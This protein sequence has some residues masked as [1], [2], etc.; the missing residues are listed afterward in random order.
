MIELAL[1]QAVVA[2]LR[3]DTDLRALISG[4][5]Y[6]ETPPQNKF[7][8]VFVGD[9]TVQESSEDYI[10]TDIEVT[11]QGFSNS[12]SLEEIFKITGLIRQILNT[13]LS[14]T[15]YQVA[16]YQHEQTSY[17]NAIQDVKQGMVSLRYKLCEAE[18]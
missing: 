1:H 8:F 18:L 15:G 13:E 3:A 17:P 14:V 6:S 9:M 5:V 12:K 2:A 4:R 16:E 7:P 10:F 11:I